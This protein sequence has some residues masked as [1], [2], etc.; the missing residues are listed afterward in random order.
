M[1]T[2]AGVD[3]PFGPP[4]QFPAPD[5]RAPAS[6]LD[7]AQ[8][9][10]YLERIT[11]ALEKQVRHEHVPWDRA[12]P[13]TIQPTSSYTLQ[14]PNPLSGFA[15]SNQTGQTIYAR[16]GDS[17]SSTS[18]DVLV[19]TGQFCRYERRDWEVPFVTFYN[20][21][22]A[23]V[24]LVVL[25][26]RPVP[27][28]NVLPLALTTAAPADGQAGQSGLIVV[29]QPSLFN[30]STWDRQ[31]GNS[32]GTLLTSASRNSST[33]TPTQINANARGVILFL[34][35]TGNPGGAETLSLAIGL[36]DP[37]SGVGSNWP[38]QSPAF[39]ANTNGFYKF[40]V[41]PGGTAALANPTVNTSM[42]GVLPRQWTAQVSHSGAGA[43]TYSLGFALIL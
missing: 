6:A 35:V 10:D 12:Y 24:T 14:T 17:C 28:L 33:G 13:I 1:S 16:L 25:V 4:P 43:W 18:Y 36:V 27:D 22:A 31:S 34:N 41:Y 21:G 11:K 38:Y 26:G 8:A 23:A 37:V 19:P 32:Q 20:P 29:S 7:L 40:I 15:F 3:R 30:G 42:S 2:T 9:A 5:D 39:P